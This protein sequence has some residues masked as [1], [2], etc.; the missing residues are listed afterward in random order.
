[1][2]SHVVRVRVTLDFLGILPMG[3]NNSPAEEQAKRMFR[4]MDVGI[5]GFVCTD[6]KFQ[7]TSKEVE[8]PPEP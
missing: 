3:G 6:K 1:M 4:M 8:N 2:T 5:A 7:V